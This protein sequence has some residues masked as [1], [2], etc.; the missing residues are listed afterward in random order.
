MA[1]LLKPIFLF[2]KIPLI[3]PHHNFFFPLKTNF[4]IYLSSGYTGMPQEFLN[5]SE[6]RA[7]I[8]EMAGEAVAEIMRSCVWI[9]VCKMFVFWK[10]F[11]D[12]VDGKL[13]AI[14]VYKYVVCGW[15]EAAANGKP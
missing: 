7:I 5:I 9:D 3:K 14:A 12:T 15:I 11:F 13:A 1:F 8:K 6:I 10:Y 4:G 2:Y